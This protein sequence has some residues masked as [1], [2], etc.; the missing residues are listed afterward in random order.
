MLRAMAI[1]ALVCA[2]GT[3]LAGPADDQYAVAAGHYSRKLWKLAVEEFKVFLE[4]YPE[5]PR[6]AQSVF[7][8]AEALLQTDATDQAETHFRQYLERE[9]AGKY[10][11]PSL[12]RAGET[13]YLLGKAGAAQAD[14]KRFVA[15]HPDD[16]L[17][18]YALPY[19]GDLAMGEGKFDAAAGFFRDGLKRFP[20]GPLLDDC[21]YGLARSLERLQQLDEAEKLYGQVVSHKGS[22]LADA[23]H[24]RLGVLQFLRSR[25]D[26]ALETLSAFETELAASPWKPK[27]QLARGWAL[28]KLKRPDEAAALF[29]SAADNAELGVEA[30]YWLGLAQREKSQWK[31]AAETL[32]AASEIDPKHHLMPAILYYAGDSLMQAGDSSGAATQLDRVRAIGGDDNTWRDDAACGKIRLALQAKNHEAVEREAREFHE[33]FPESP[34][35]GQVDRMLT[36]ALVEQRKFAE[37][38]KLLEPMIAA[39][40]DG[41]EA[42][43]NRYLLAAAQEGLHEFDKA[44]ATLVP[45]LEQAKGK[46]K[47]DAQLVVGSSLLALKRYSEAIAPLESFLTEKPEGDTAVRARGA[48]AV[49]YA[50]TGKLEES[51]TLFSPLVEIQPDHA[52]LPAVAE[53]LGEAAYAAG[54]VE[55]AMSLFEW[56]SH[57]GGTPEYR[58]KGLSGAAWSSYKLEKLPEA[59]ALFAELLES[60]PPAPMA[61][62]ASLA[63]GRILEEMGQLDAALALYDHVVEN[64]ADAKIKEYPLALLAAAR[65]RRRL[66][67]HRQSVELYKRLADEFP[68]LP[69][70][71]VVLYEWSWVLFDQSDVD[72]SN[73]LLA[74]LRTEYPQSRYWT[75]ATYRLAVRGFQAKKYSAA[76]KLCTEIIDSDVQGDLREHSLYLLARIAAVEAEQNGKWD[77]VSER[78][79][80]LLESFPNTPTRLVAEFWIAESLYRQQKYPESLAEFERLAQQTQGQSG[81]WLAM[82]PL[83]RAQLLAHQRKWNEAYAVASK[84]GERFPSFPQQYEADYVVGRCLAA[85]AD[86]DGARQAYEKVINSEQ[87]AKTETAAMAQWMIGETFF[88]QKRYDVAMREYLRVARLYAYP[89]WQAGALLQGAKCRELLGEPEEAAKLYAEVLEEYA[90]TPFAEQAK[91]RLVAARSG[92]PESSPASTVEN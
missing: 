19:L 71:D 39:K 26:A 80:R 89:K 43:E 29:Q 22:P 40:P 45:V 66:D 86:F 18:A 24:F 69:E 82:I 13:A 55:W 7:F 72:A 33:S 3:V 77:L 58:R 92:Q 8:L 67:Q 34:L 50:R 73:A 57:N 11:T 2:G 90:D 75:D 52:L 21:R 14:L 81:D 85:L 25:Y 4:K 78:F 91:E 46:L 35:R 79:Q 59:A 60:E 87:G 47:S 23:A 48:L 64:H 68:K 27:A 41:S 31:L 49:A 20:E 16:N 30:R 32:L 9:P 42:L 6:A 51:K 65:L 54:N 36:R 84:I 63:R 37:A 10:A 15:E 1:L 62:E 83:R 61:A 28:M 12:F 74:K 88:H 38:T 17:N 76:A 53:Q 56:L 44:L 70:R 5:H